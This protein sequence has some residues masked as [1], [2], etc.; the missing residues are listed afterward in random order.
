MPLVVGGEATGV[1]SLQN[2][3]REHA[4]TESDLQ[5]LATLARSLSVALENARLVDE[6]RQRAAE[7]AI[8]N[9]VGQA[10]S[11]HLDLP[12]LIDLVGERMRETFDADIVYVAL[13]EPA[14]DIIDFPYYSELGK[15]ITSSPIAFGEGLT[16]RILQ[17]RAPLL[18]N[19]AQHFEEIG[20]RGLGVPAESY[21]GVP[22]MAG[23]TAIGVISVQ[24]SVHQGRFGEAD[25][26]LLST[27]AANVGVVIQNAQLYEETRRRGDE[28]AALAEV[29]RELSAAVD[30]AAVVERIAERAKDLLEADT[31][32]VYL[33]EPED[34]TF[35]A[36]V[37]L[38]RERRRD[39]G[40][41][42]RA[43]RGNHRRPRRP[44]RRRRSSTT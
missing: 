37:A 44:R 35:R 41:S 24:S 2:L 18:L 3:D 28:M 20:T 23:E 11:A 15:R 40:G 38:G 6:T 27:I 14:S 8:V 32:A 29:G 22:I 21:L 16:S 10:L 17:S 34:R 5:L 9:S 13:H 4:F 26:R 33:V 42:D 39:Q 12:S 30:M 43:R 1:I 36:T 25:V 31:S 19:R 7:L